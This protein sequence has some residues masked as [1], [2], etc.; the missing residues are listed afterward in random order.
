MQIRDNPT[1]QWL[2][3]VS[4]PTEMRD[5]NKYCRFHQDHGHCTDECRHLKDQVETLIRQGKLQKYIRKTDPHRY[6]WKDDQDRTPKVKNSKP[7]TGEIKLIL[8]GLTT[9]GTLKSLKK[10][11]GRE[12]NNVH[13]RLP[14]MKMLKNDE[15]N[16]VFSKR[17]S[18]GIRQSHDDLLVIMLR[19]EEFNIHWVLIDNE[20]SA[21]IIYLPMFQQMKLDKKRIRPF[22]SPLET[23]DR[24]IPRG[25]VTLI[26]ITGTYPA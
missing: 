6:Q 22:T 23:R 21:D 9:G 5:K 18:H 11:Q 13:S 19:V 10:A 17:D 20:S 24:I 16:F 2:K 1:L 3:P 14:Q 4:T 8:G 12:I 7:P 26:V 15:P 25:I